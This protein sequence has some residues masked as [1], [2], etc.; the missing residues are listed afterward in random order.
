[1]GYSKRKP[2]EVMMYRMI[3]IY[4]IIL[5]S[6]VSSQDARQ[7][8]IQRDTSYTLHS[9]YEKYKKD[10]PFIKPIQ[11]DEL[12]GCLQH[13]NICY[14]SL[15]KRTLS[16]D[17]FSTAEK[18]EPMKPAVITVHG[19]G[20]SSGDKS[21][22]YP[23]ADYLAKHGY[24]AIPVEYRLSP[25]AR[26]PAAVNDIHNAVAWVLKNGSAY[27]V[28]TNK[29]AILGC[30]AG[31]QLAGLVGLTFGVNKNDDKP[32]RKRI[33]A[34]VNIDGIMDFT[35]EEARKYEDN[36]ARK[37]TAAGAWFGGRYSEKKEL[38][39]EAS[40]VYYVNENSPPILFINS[41]MPR[42]HIGRDKVIEKLNTF[43]IYS[44][45]HTFEDAPHSFWLFDPWFEKTGM[46]IVEF[47]DRVLK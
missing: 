15:G 32:P 1:M 43:S 36:P 22:M 41:S 14:C 45:I 12:K 27:Q 29:I 10:Y 13:R 42:F 11:Y 17:I 19:G 18:S 16:L 38:W 25:E 20:W 44:E 37:T 5:T 40:P 33:R 7:F 23:L 34:I 4:F 31:A 35:S 30:S 26:Y 9:A 28:D 3:I 6:I 47:L 8:T 2:S 39:K 21:L 24:V 46:F